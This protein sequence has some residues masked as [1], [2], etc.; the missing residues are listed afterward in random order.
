MSVPTPLRDLERPRE[1]GQVRD[2]Q[3][4]GKRRVRD[5]KGWVRDR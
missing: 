5:S 1:A 3:G 4:T 2:G